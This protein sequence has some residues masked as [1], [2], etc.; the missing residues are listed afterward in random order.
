M[1]RHISRFE[2]TP[3]G[4]RMQIRCLAKTLQS[5]PVTRLSERRTWGDDGKAYAIAK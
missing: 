4:G 2:L 3:G 5:H 1:L